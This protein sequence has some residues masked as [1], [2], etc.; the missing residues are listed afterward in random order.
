MSPSPHISLIPP[1]GPSVLKIYSEPLL[2]RSTVPSIFLD[3][4]AVRIAVFVDEQKCRGAIEIDAD[5]PRSWHWVAFATSRESDDSRAAAKELGSGKTSAAATI[6]LVPVSPPSADGEDNAIEGIESPPHAPTQMWD[7][8]EPY[9]KLGRLATLS[10]YRGLGLAR[11]L[12]NAALEWAAEN[13]STL[14]ATDNLTFSEEKREEGEG[15]QVG[16]GK[17]EN[18]GNVKD[19]G[20]NGLVLVHAQTTVESFYKRS[21]FATDV[22][23]GRWYEDG[24]EH[25]AMWKRLEL[26]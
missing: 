13:A 21:G 14:R 5:D 26:K 19:N 9:I 24:I 23:M 25:L 1:P 20:W 7:G 2:S 4:Y 17:E 18:N 11:L 8:H 12:V 22:G 10:A 15:Q 3:A 16:Q 6:R